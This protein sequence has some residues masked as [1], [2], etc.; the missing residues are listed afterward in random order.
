[1][2]KIKKLIIPIVDEDAAEY[3][4]CLQMTVTGDI[5]NQRS[6]GEE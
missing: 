5:L 4:C 1:M 2:D 6:D 3:P